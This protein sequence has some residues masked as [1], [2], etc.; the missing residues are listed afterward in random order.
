LLFFI[1]QYIV[2]RLDSVTIC[3]VSTSGSNSPT[4]VK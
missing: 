4:S 3:S 1:L 2:D